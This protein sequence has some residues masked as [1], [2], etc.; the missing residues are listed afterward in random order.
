MRM[1]HEKV[2]G[3]TQR[4]RLLLSDWDE[5]AA[6]ARGATSNQVAA[7]HIF[8][9]WLV[10]GR[11][12]VQLSPG[13]VAALLGAV[14]VTALQ[15]GYVPLPP[16][17]AI[18]IHVEDS[19]PVEVE[20]SEGANDGDVTIGATRSRQIGNAKL[21]G[22]VISADA[23][24]QDVALGFVAPGFADIRIVCVGLGDIVLGKWGDTTARLVVAALRALNNERAAWQEPGQLRSRTQQRRAKKIGLRITKLVLDEDAAS[25]W[26]RQRL[27]ET[28]RES[29]V[30]EDRKAPTPHWVE[31]H[32][33]RRWVKEPHLGE[34]ILD[35]KCVSEGPPARWLYCVMRPRKGHARGHGDLTTTTERVVP[36]L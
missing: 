2:A 14:D 10:A 13:T 12:V 7:Y 33:A 34:D 31:E 3:T 9:E 22:L 21:S 28:S 27:L 29:C 23:L 8:R 18:Q 1:M 17:K 11:R 6:R 26:R 35:S 32:L 5:S 24:Q 4:V 20:I 16:V 30:V 15:A 19:I 25:V 36:Q